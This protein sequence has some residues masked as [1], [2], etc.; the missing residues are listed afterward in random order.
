M[1]TRVALAQSRD[2]EGT[3]CTLAAYAVPLHTVEESYQEGEKDWQLFIREAAPRLRVRAT[4]QF[5]SRQGYLLSFSPTGRY[6]A[7][8]LGGETLALWNSQTG[9][10][11]PPC[12]IS[13]LEDYV[14]V[15]EEQKGG[16]PQVRLLCAGQRGLAI[17]TFSEGQWE[18]AFKDNA[19]PLCH[20][21]LSAAT[22]QVALSDANLGEPTI[23]MLSTL[24]SPSTRRLD[25]RGSSDPGPE[26]VYTRATHNPLLW[27][28][29]TPSGS[30]LLLLHG[31]GELTLRSTRDQRVIVPLAHPEHPEYLGYRDF[32]RFPGAPMTFSPDGRR[33]VA[34]AGFGLLF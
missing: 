22:G 2:G 27:Y 1:R 11:F 24:L 32:Q 31:A 18:I 33:L 13:G 8:G 15:S 4:S 9:Q 6:L 14:F 29:F 34:R 17:V 12:T 3:A 30:Y 16:S 28:T 19:A 21:A 7:A 25:R 23:W 20:I 26:L 10:A 5:A